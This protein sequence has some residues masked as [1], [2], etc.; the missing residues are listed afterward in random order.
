MLPK[1]KRSVMG[2]AVVDWSL[3][4]S[5]TPAPL[6]VGIVRCVGGQAISF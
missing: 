1:G 3:V 6:T 4:A 2:A 5:I